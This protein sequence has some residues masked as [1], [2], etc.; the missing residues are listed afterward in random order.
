MSDCYNLKYIDALKDVLEAA[1][2]KTFYS[3]KDIED[4]ITAF[5]LYLSKGD[6][7]YYYNTTFLMRKH[8]AF[9]QFITKAE[10]RRVALVGFIET[11]NQDERV[12]EWEATHPNEKDA[13]C[14]RID[15]FFQ[16]DLSGNVSICD[17]MLVQGIEYGKKLITICFQGR[18]ASLFC[19]FTDEEKNRAVEI[20]LN[21]VKVAERKGEV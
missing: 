16:S 15:D 5:S 11:L 12:K 18:T 10:E 20:F 2:S 19:P 9:R 8:L 21:L 13:T 4:Y 17:D 7:A 14:V 3:Q 6:D 1:E